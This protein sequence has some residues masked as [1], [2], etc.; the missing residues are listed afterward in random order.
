MSRRLDSN[1]S[2]RLCDRAFS[3]AAS[4]V[5]RAHPFAMVRV[6]RLKLAT[7]RKSPRRHMPL[8]VYSLCSLTVASTRGLTTPA[9]RCGDSSACRERER[10]RERRGGEAAAEA[11]TR[12]AEG[13]NP[14]HQALASPASHDR[15]AHIVSSPS[16]HHSMRSSRRRGCC[17]RL[18]LN[19]ASQTCAATCRRSSS[20]RPTTSRS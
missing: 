16:F 19:V 18:D 8:V 17:I 10:E 3:P 2:R 1:A 14:Q 9:L 11:R 12:E 20:R 6:V 7:R 5:S 15:F 13:C 4:W